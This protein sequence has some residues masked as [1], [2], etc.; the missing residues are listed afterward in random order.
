MSYYCSV[1]FPFFFCFFF[2][3]LFVLVLHFA[4]IAL[5]APFLLNCKGTGNGSVL[6]L[7]CAVPIFLLLVSG[8]VFCFFAGIDGALIFHSQSP[9]TVYI[10]Q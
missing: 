1:Q 3:F 2:C 8:V 10:Y 6:L 7:Q 4:S 5:I 9:M